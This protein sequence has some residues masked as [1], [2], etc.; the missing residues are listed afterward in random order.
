[1]KISIILRLRETTLFKEIRSATHD[2][3]AQ[4][5]K[6][7]PPDPFHDAIAIDG[8]ALVHL[9]PVVNI[10]T[11][12]YASN[13]FVPYVTKQLQTSTRVDLVWDTYIDRSTKASTREKRGKG[14]K[15]KV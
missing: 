7:D 14:I 3:L 15:G 10:I 6:Q 4:K 2:I 9:L 13:V 1:M 5:S 11:P 12:V 8:A